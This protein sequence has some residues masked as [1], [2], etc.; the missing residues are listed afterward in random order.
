LESNNNYNNNYP[1]AIGE[2]N[3]ELDGILAMQD[4]AAIDRVSFFC[5][6]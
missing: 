4:L 3:A 6:K 1:A 2:G 5:F